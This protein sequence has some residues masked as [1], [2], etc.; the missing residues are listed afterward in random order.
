L[1]IT[2][3]RHQVALLKDDLKL[4]GYEEALPQLEAMSVAGVMR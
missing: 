1:S 3:V 2:Q 4:L